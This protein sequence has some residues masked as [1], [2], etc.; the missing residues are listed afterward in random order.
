MASPRSSQELSS[1]AAVAYENTK[2]IT[3][4]PAHVVTH[5]GVVHIRVNTAF[6]NMLSYVRMSQGKY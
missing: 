3:C 1:A 4:L 5:S 6:E 2:P